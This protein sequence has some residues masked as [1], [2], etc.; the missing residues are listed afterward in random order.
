MH[1]KIIVILKNI[2]IFHNQLHVIYYIKVIFNNK[3]Y[4][5]KINKLKLC[6]ILCN[7]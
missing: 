7:K 1:L 3:K 5:T 4:N 2:F 6:C